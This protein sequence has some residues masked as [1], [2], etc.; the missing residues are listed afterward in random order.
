MAEVAKGILSD[1]RSI[2]RF[3]KASTI[4]KMKFQNAAKQSHKPFSDLELGLNVLEL[5][6]LL[7]M[8]Y[9]MKTV[10]QPGNMFSVENH[11]SNK[12]WFMQ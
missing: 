1:Q 2:N 3:L 5:P 10:L 12:Q 8:V 9:V 4:Q 7:K 6:L 11:D